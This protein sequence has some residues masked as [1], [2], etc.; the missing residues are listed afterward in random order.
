VVI[1]SQIRERLSDEVRLIERA[2]VCVRWW[3]SDR[4]EAEFVGDFRSFV[5]RTNTVAK[6][7]MTYRRHV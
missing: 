3:M 6:M 2:P 1:A 7:E 4:K 5:I